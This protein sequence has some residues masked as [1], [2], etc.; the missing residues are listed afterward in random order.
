MFEPWLGH[1][2]NPMP[3]D[4]VRNQCLFQPWSKSFLR[5]LYMV[6]E[7]RKVSL[8]FGVKD[9]LNASLDMLGGH[10]HSLYVA[11]GLPIVGG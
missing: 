4:T 2:E 10:T 3:L 7:R 8:S 11:W 9:W 6:T 5:I 1:T